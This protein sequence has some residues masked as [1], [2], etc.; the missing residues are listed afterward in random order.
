MNL[1]E[2]LQG[3]INRQKGLLEKAKNE[4]R[5]FTAEE[6]TEW[7]TIQADID[8]TKGMIAAEEQLEVTNKE[9]NIP[10]TPAPHVEVKPGQVE[11]VFSNLLENLRSCKNAQS[12]NVD[13]KMRKVM[14][15]SGGQSGVGEDGGFLIEKQ[16]TQGIL[17]SAVDDSPILSRVKKLPI[18]AGF[19]GAK[20]TDVDEKSV[21]TSV[22]GGVIA[23]WA[24][25]AATVTGTKPVFNKREISLQKLMGLAYVTD[26]LDEDSVFVSLQNRHRS[27]SSIGN[28]LR[29]RR[30][31]AARYPFFCRYGIGCQGKRSDRSNGRMGKPCQDV[32]SRKAQP[33]FRVD[34]SSGRSAAA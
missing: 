17:K 22:Y 1:K 30:R 4:G 32:Q 19:N 21:A 33:F 2:R 7:K 8:N 12:G 27:R 24:G 26:E 18:G 20:W 16:F 11:N 29:Q 3:L 28:H 14:N 31:E 6:N 34:S 10:V 23:Y 9:L 15:A 25:E 5:V 13:D